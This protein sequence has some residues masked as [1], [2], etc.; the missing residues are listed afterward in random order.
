MHITL[1]QLEIFAAIAHSEN[2]SQAA[3]ALALSQSATSS[4]LAELERQFNC[5]L[6]DRI[7]KSLRLN[8]QGRALLPR[9]EDILARALEIENLLDG[10]TLGPVAVCATLTIG[11]YLAPLV[12]AAYSRQHPESSID[13]SVANTAS[14][15]DRLVRC[16]YDL[17]LIEGE[18]HHPELESETWLDDRLTVFC[19]PG[20]P[21]A[22]RPHVDTANLLKQHWIMREPGSSTRNVLE[23]ALGPDCHKLNI[24]LTLEHTEAIKRAVEA[25]L[26]IACLSRLSL[27]AAIQRGSLVELATPQLDLSRRFLF[28]WHRQRK[29]T[30]AMQTFMRLSRQLSGSARDTDELSLP[31]YD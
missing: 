12:V 2:A 7:G 3:R 20:H 21:L 25:G 15:V 18:V 6:F 26:G 28:V 14:V 1:R 29:K 8:G 4:A 30:V 24:T 17:G 13:F 31:N 5:P 9:A 23:N 27:R 11:N 22:K 16:Q 10:K 19:A